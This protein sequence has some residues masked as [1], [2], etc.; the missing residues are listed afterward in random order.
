MVALPHVWLLLEVGLT[1]AVPVVGHAAALLLVDALVSR[2]ERDQP[3]QIGGGSPPPCRELLGADVI[4]RG[5][6]PALLF[7]RHS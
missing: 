3:N 5:G 4:R 6:G 2:A 7:S 1:V